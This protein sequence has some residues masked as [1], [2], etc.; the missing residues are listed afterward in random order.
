MYST[1]TVHVWGFYR[2]RMCQCDECFVF[3]EAENDTEFLTETSLSHE[4]ER[5]IIE[6][7]R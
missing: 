5:P 3:L 4:E 2:R 7:T 1:C 6:L